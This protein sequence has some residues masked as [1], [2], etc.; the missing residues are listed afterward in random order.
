MFDASG[1]K[2]YGEGEWKVR[3]HGKSKRRTWRKIHIA[4]D[5]NTHDIVL[6]ELTENS[7]NDCNVLK[8]LL[9]EMG[10]GLLRVYGDGIYDTEGCYEA[11]SKKKAEPLIPARRNAKYKHSAKDHLQARNQQILD[12]VAL[13]GDEIARSLWKKLK[14]YHKRSLGET[15]FFRF[16]TI[17]GHALK[18]RK[19]CIQIIECKIKCMILNKMNQ[20]GLPLSYIA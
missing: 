12:I 6:A 3:T 20:L 15:S 2:V 19:M 14:G 11:I 4:M 5:P 8:N 10:S 18:S 7:S 9:E 13:G 17:L 16:K 1:L